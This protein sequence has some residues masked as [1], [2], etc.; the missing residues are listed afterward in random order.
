[1]EHDLFDEIEVSFAHDELLEIIEWNGL[2]IKRNTAGASPLRCSG[3]LGTMSPLRLLK[4]LTHSGEQGV[5][6]SFGKLSYF[7]FLNEIID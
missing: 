6:L 3:R 4:T 5:Q 1:M 2:D 7:D